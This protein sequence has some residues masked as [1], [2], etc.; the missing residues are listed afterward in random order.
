MSV[1]HWVP[2]Q[3]MWDLLCCSASPGAYPPEGL[4]DARYHEIRSTAGTALRVVG[5]CCCWSCRRR[6]WAEQQRDHQKEGE[7]ECPGR[8]VLA[9][10][11]TL[12]V[13][14]SF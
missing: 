13:I 4:Y 6:E 1:A 14:S 12:H 9:S 2:A 10:R 7:E 11:R 3:W 8:V 5:G